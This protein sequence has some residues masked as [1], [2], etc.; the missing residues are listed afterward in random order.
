V[1]GQTRAYH[2]G[3]DS[4]LVVAKINLS[5]EDITWMSFYCYS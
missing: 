2:T 3:D 5:P 1:I 4:T